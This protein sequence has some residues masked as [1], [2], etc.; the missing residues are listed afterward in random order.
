[1]SSHANWFNILEL[2]PKQTVGQNLDHTYL[3]QEDRQLPDLQAGFKIRDSDNVYAPTPSFLSNVSGTRLPNFFEQLTPAHFSYFQDSYVPSMGHTQVVGLPTA[4]FVKVSVDGQPLQ[5]YN[6]RD[7]RGVDPKTNNVDDLW[8][9]RPVTAMTNKPTS[10]GPAPGGPAGYGDVENPDP[11]DEDDGPDIEDEDSRAGDF[12]RRLF[13]EEEEEEHGS[14]S[15]P[16][17][18]SDKSIDYGMERKEEPRLRRRRGIPGEW[19]RGRGGAGSAA[20]ARASIQNVMEHMERK[21][22]DME[23]SMRDFLRDQVEGDNSVLMQ[24]LYGIQERLRMNENQMEARNPSLLG[25]AVSDLGNRAIVLEESM[26]AIQALFREFV[27][28]S[29]A[30]RLEM[31]QTL[32]DIRIIMEREY[33]QMREQVQGLE[34]KQGLATVTRDASGR[35]VGEN[36]MLKELL[37]QMVTGN[38]TMNENISLGRQEQKERDIALVDVLTNN[39]NETTR[40]S[41]ETNQLVQDSLDAN[42]ANTNAISDMKNDNERVNAQT[43]RTLGQIT[44]ALADNAANMSA[45]VD[46]LDTSSVR[47]DNGNTLAA[48]NRGYRDVG[49]AIAR[50][51]Q[52]LQDGNARLSNEDFK[53]YEDLIEGVYSRIDRNFKQQADEMKGQSRVEQTATLQ[54]LFERQTLDITRSINDLNQQIENVRNVGNE[55]TQGLV[56]QLHYVGHELAK[57]N[58]RQIADVLARV[59]QVRNIQPIDNDIEMKNDLVQEVGDNAARNGHVLRILNPIGL[60]VAMPALEPLRNIND[61][62]RAVNLPLQQFGPPPALE[63]A[64]N[65]NDPVRN[66]PALVRNMPALEPL[67]NIND[68]VLPIVRIRGRDASILT[69]QRAPKR[70]GTPSSFAA[71]IDLSDLSDDSDAQEI[72]VENL[73]SPPNSNTINLTI[74]SPS[75]NSDEVKSPDEDVGELLP[76]DDDTGIDLDLDT[77]LLNDWNRQ[78][79]N[80]VRGQSQQWQELRNNIHA[81]LGELANLYQEYGMEAK[82]NEINN[83]TGVTDTYTEGQLSHIHQRLVQEYHQANRVVQESNMYTLRTIVNLIEGITANNEQTLMANQF[84][85][86]MANNYEKLIAMRYLPRINL[87]D[88][89]VDIQNVISENKSNGVLLNIDLGEEYFQEF[90]RD[91]YV[92]YPTNEQSSV[93]DANQELAVRTPVPSLSVRSIGGT[94]G[95]GANEML[96]T[97]M[98]IDSPGE[99]LRNV[100]EFPRPSRNVLNVQQARNFM[101]NLGEKRAKLK[102]L[103]KVYDNMNFKRLTI[104][105]K[106][107]LLWLRDELKK[108]TVAIKELRG[109]SSHYFKEAL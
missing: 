80:V 39:N 33:S 51:T 67:R 60:Q 15:E 85:P 86:Y 75:G 27:N 89:L 37:Q 108:N 87:M 93:N 101:Q 9:F 5:A 103:L 50:Q 88:Y 83:L 58:R 2:V 82:F 84:A 105:Q 95:G 109:N 71:L 79:A 72:N 94:G 54:N 7:V 57:D 16:G 48:I 42:T 106:Q 12:M 38:R 35:S 29:G 31:R 1:M 66:M 22:P 34:E 19:M 100:S 44:N 77:E 25:R 99:H 3:V 92:H 65:I 43:S 46:T 40:R 78:S 53:R 74:P 55:N 104:S 13:H 70:A 24:T 97:K 64:R 4:H 26:A 56:G 69:G 21:Y 23:G 68:P 96:E 18:G 36:E 73:V 59:N 32:N 6:D 10:G 107:Y 8:P 30:D 102:A 98:D 81:I 49:D 63:P 17:D 11:A 20:S 41:N 76:Y 14:I 52:H 61:P 90:P 45:F 62:V 28:S 91:A 47:Q